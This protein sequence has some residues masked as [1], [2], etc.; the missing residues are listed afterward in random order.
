LSETKLK[1]KNI[2]DKKLNSDY[3]IV[4]NANDRIKRL[5]KR[6]LDEKPYISIERALFY[7][8]KWKEL[9]FTT[10]SV[11]I[12]VALSMKHVYEN[13]H[14]YIDPDD[15]IFGTW[16]EN[17]LGIP[18]D[19]E[20]GLFNK[21]FE[22][23]L[24]KR[25]MRLFGLKENINFAFYKIRKDGLRSLLN[26]L[27]FSKKIGAAMPSLGTGT[28]DNRKINPYQ[29]KNTDKKILLKRL[30]PYWKKKNIADM[31]QKAFNEHRIFKG[32]FGGFIDH[33]PRGTAQNDMVTSLGAAL[34]VWQGHLILDHETPM[35]KGL[36]QMQNEVQQLI[37]NKNSLNQEELNFL[38]SIDVALEGVIIYARRLT[39]KV[40]E[41]KKMN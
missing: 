29:I 40:K 28:L 7:T 34:G 6:F 3:T 13:M 23:E 16:T 21:V 1:G 9:E 12:R 2:S 15:K 20:R 30:L 14:Y 11:G 19:I 32:E 18:I 4:D 39:E 26:N 10:L 17:F 35:K 31:L 37:I 27:R 33:L 8:E 41:L 25:K 24:N 38:R 36:L 22:I 5:R